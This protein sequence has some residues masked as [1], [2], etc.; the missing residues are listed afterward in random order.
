[1]NITN[2]NSF[3]RKGT[4]FKQPIHSPNSRPIKFSEGHAHDFWKHQTLLEFRRRDTQTE[5]PLQQQIA[6]LES[7]IDMHTWKRKL[8][9]AE[10]QKMK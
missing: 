4:I 1:M 9:L 6:Y 2:N 10:G 7:V 3:T 5:K 8:P